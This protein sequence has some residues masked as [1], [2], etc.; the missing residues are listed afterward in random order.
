M[1]QSGRQGSAG[2]W[3][4]E[5]RL[6]RRLRSQERGWFRLCSRRAL[7]FPQSL[8]PARASRRN[9]QYAEGGVPD[10]LQGTVPVNKIN[11]CR[12]Y[13]YGLPRN[14][15]E[16][17]CRIAPRYF[18]PRCHDRR[19]R[20]RPCILTGWKTRCLFVG[21]SL[22]GI[23]FSAVCA[24]R[25]CRETKT[26]VESKARAFRGGAITVRGRKKREL[27]ETSIF[28]SV[29]TFH[30]STNSL[31]KLSARLGYSSA[32]FASSMCLLT[33]ASRQTRATGIRLKAIYRENIREVRSRYFWHFQRARLWSF[34]S[35]Y[36]DV[37]A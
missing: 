17:A 12:I 37:Y 21:I 24:P 25:R 8:F 1:E 33:L 19:Q 36:L 31:S 35:P 20:R 13:M 9:R 27:A 6:M 29:K 4:T 15:A 30:E 32:F 7:A 28:R 26:R 10:S 3:Y 18:A 14:V 34:A 11:S 2:V 23:G 16:R 5:S 22:S